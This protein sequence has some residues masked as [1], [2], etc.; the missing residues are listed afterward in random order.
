[1]FK[2][3]FF[4]TVFSFFV[5]DSNS[6]ATAQ[7]ST[8]FIPDSNMPRD[9]IP[10]DFKWNTSHLFAND[11]AW[12][13]SYSEVSQELEQLAQ[14]KGTL[15]TPD[16]IK[17][18]LDF[19]FS[20][21]KKIT[22]LA[23]YARLQ[24]ET[25]QTDN[26][27]LDMKKK[28]LSLVNKQLKDSSFIREEIL[29][30][31]PAMLINAGT[32]GILKEYFTTIDNFL[33]RKD[34]VLSGGEERLLAMAGD[35][36]WA[37]IDINELPSDTELTFQSFLSEI[38][39]PE[40]RDEE[41]KPVRLNLSNYPKYRR[42]SDREVRKNT[43]AVFFKQIK[44][45]QNTLASTLSGQVKLSSFFAKARGYNQAI[46]AYLDK[47]NVSTTVY[48]NL[49][50][51]AHQNLDKLHRYVTLRKKIM[52]LDNIH[53]YDLYVP[54]IKSVQLH[55][56]YP[57]AIT[58]ITQALSPLG[59]KYAD[60]L[61]TN[62]D[63]KTGWVDLY[64]HQDK[65]S[66][67]SC[68]SVYGMHPYV[69]MNYFG[70]YD[71][72]STLAHEFGHAMHSHYAMT[73][74]P[75]AA[76]NYAVFIAET[77]STINETLLLDTMIAD[78][79]TKEEKLYFLNERLETIRTTIFRQTLFAEFEREIHR[80]F[81]NGTPLTADLLNKTYRELIQKYYGPDF[82]IDANDDIEWA[83]IPHFYYK[84]YMYNYATG[85]SSGIAFAENIKANGESAAEKYLQML[86]NG[87][88][89]PPLTLMKEAG[90]DMSEPAAI[91]AAFDL[92][93][94]TLDEMEKLL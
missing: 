49:I 62:M 61:K 7:T 3:Y 19:Y 65:D 13:S 57:T 9:N 93:G 25:H 82:V 35:N 5:V 50:N 2:K 52:G 31:D 46:E 4:I 69:K 38:A 30:A 27:Y 18:A 1:M 89:K 24:E 6:L 80:L 76:A 17:T 51:T 84:F 78:A 40:I 55:Y 94:R 54:M 83:Y 43:V 21:S 73:H 48:D 53:I 10:A 87:Q 26:R 59:R 33:R 36:L 88:S 85:L 45:Y 92:F 8:G 74:Q 28:A 15:T 12:E 23:L 64:P 90:V 79:K 67:A 22:W 86:K 66:G 70:E 72:L 16:K 20:L 56:D 58:T 60:E 44:Q 81:E 42:S 29:K 71:D 32:K 91:Q 63:L 77:A 39:F 34:R 68:N 41:G 14:F 11:A 37:E 47:E 75:Y